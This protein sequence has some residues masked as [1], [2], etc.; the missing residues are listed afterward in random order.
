M[1]SVGN[2]ATPKLGQDRGDF[3]FLGHVLTSK[4]TGHDQLSL[5]NPNRSV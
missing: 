1:Y 4:N 2:Q 3:S 5:E